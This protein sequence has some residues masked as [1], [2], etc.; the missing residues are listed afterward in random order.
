GG[1]DRHGDK[2]AETSDA[3]ASQIANNLAGSAGAE[4]VKTAVFAHHHPQTVRFFSLSTHYRTSIDLSMENLSNTGKSMEGFYRMFETFQ[5][6]TGIDF[7]S[8]EAPTQRDQTVD[9]SGL[10]ADS[11]TVLTDL[12]DRFLE[13][14]DDDF[15]TGG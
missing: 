7:Y 4:S 1:R 9:L 15:N 14:M 11:K 13:A 3:A 8:L 6:V 2:P 5:R 10:S 12:R